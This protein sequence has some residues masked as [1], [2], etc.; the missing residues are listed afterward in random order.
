M[1]LVSTIIRIYYRICIKVHFRMLDL[2]EAVLTQNKWKY[3]R[4][5]G[6]MLLNHRTAELER[7]KKSSEC[8]LLLMSLK[9]GG[10]GLNVTE[11]N[12]VYLLDPWWNRKQ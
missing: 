4:L 6:E 7:F 5:D 12:Y 3:G 1:D 2:V 10:V 11:A 9:V 8:N